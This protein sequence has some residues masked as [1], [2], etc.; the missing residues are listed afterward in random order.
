MS[1]KYRIRVTADRVIGP[2]SKEEVAELYEKKHIT[3]EE[4][5]QLF[6]VGSWK[7]IR[8][9][10]ALVDFV[11]NK[12]ISEPI[13]IDDTE[14]KQFQAFQ[15]EKV[16]HQDVNYDELEKKYKK[17]KAEEAKIEAAA[18]TSVESVKIPEVEKTQIRHR[19]KNEDLDK[20]R[21]D[22]KKAA[23]KI[24]QD[25]PDVKEN[26]SP[27]KPLP[28]IVQTHHERV[29]EKTQFLDLKSVLPA[30]NTELRVAEIDFEQQERIEENQDKIIE[31][32]HDSAHK[33]EEKELKP[34][35]KTRGMKPIIAIAFIAI[36][37]VLLN[38]DE[39]PVAVVPIYTQV[40]FPITLEF[41]DAS[42]S[43]LSL[44]KGKAEYAIN[45]YPTRVAASRDFIDSLQN[46]FRSNE[47]LGELILTYS[48]LLE[49]AQDEKQASNIVYKLIML[50]ENKTFSDSKIVTGTALF[51]YKIGKYQ[52]G[53]NLIKNFFRAK[54]KPTPKLLGYYLDLLISAGDL[55]EATKI[56]VKL[57]EISK[58]PFET[59]LSLARYFESDEKNDLAEAVILEGLKL[60]PK[61]VPL[62]LRQADFLLKK[63]SL[64][65]FQAILKKCN[66][67]NLELSPYYTAKYYKLMGF[68]AA[69]KNKN[70]E[71]AGFFK[72]SLAIIESDD[73]RAIL[74][75]LEIKGDKF[76]QA[77]ILESKIIELMKKAD[78]ELKN[79]NMET[80]LALS[81]EAVDADPDYIPSV[82]QHVKI[83]LQK[84]LYDA[85]MFSLNKILDKQ[86]LN[87]PVRKMLVE[88]NLKALRYDDAQRGLVELSKTKFGFSGG[89]ASLMARFFE[90]KKTNQLAIR[91]Y[92]EALKRNPLLDNDMFNL[93]KIYFKI[94]KFEEAKKYLGKA[95]TLDPKNID[96][97]T[98]QADILY[99]QDGAD[100]ALGY[101]RDIIAELGE[102]PLLIS[103]IA[104]IYYKTGQIKEFQTYYKKILAMSKKDEAFFEFLIYASKLEDSKTDFVMY[105]NELL[106]INPGN[107]TL[108]M[109]L[110]EF[111]IR[112]G[113][114]QAALTHLVQV[115]DKLK[116][117]PRLHYLLSKLSLMQGDLVRAKE[118]AEKEKIYNPTLELPYVMLGEIAMAKKDY[119]EAFTQFE[120][121]LSLNTKSV[122]ALVA[123]GS[124]K[125][126]Q[127]HSS[128]ALDL[129]LLANKQDK[130]NPE[131]SKQ[132][133]FAYRAA[134]Q[135][136]QGRERFEDYLKLNPGATDRNQIEALIRSLK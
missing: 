68:L 118:M 30:L 60:Y 43:S 87:I 70:K 106:K 35:A 91:W 132:L 67:L 25:I 21:I 75:S 120:K 1:L 94:K 133:G 98:L 36:I 38:P 40:V 89:Y 33:E 86:P 124:I 128:E 82:L 80:A 129:L 71:A 117:Y 95:L 73:L 90:G 13:I 78:I 99:E 11:F 103:T 27:S 122:D 131:I 83:Q 127:N 9:F 7:S 39:A 6:P 135:R 116:S 93:A 119:R 72:K 8:L 62:L 107:L 114:L 19:P 66:K 24:H 44:Q 61:S 50:A 23:I 58:K 64:E 77:L 130:N 59:Y 92:N 3:G 123:M 100:T 109:E 47:A 112:T 84:G 136:S 51:Y 49:N 115:E 32:E 17:T 41:E 79:R 29:S 4:E 54:G 22:L 42:K 56:A 76:S 63:K 37:Y 74:A 85:A 125:L 48:E 69:V 20:T 26:L 46:Q 108:Q 110:A 65:K 31:R 28:A 52:T 15:F 101:L 121:A 2:F 34:K 105:A 16:D 126:L 5:C 96:Y 113:D 88:T 10:P 102:T 97:V 81:V 134:G 12:K 18:K 45:T 14:K 57:N 53:V 111:Y 104:K 55:A